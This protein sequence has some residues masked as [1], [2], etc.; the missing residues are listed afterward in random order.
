LLAACE[1]VARAEFDRVDESSVHSPDRAC[2][3]RREL[4]REHG[5]IRSRL[6]GFC[7]NS[8]R[9]RRAMPS[10][11]YS[12]FM[13]D[14]ALNRSRSSAGP[15]PVT[16][17]S[18]VELV[19][20]EVRRSILEG[21]LPPGS[22]VS[23]AELSSRLEV[24]HIPVREALRRLEGEGLIELRRARSAVV[25]SLTTDDL[26]DVFR[27]RGLIEAD[28]FARAV[29]LYTDEDLEEIEAAYDALLREPDDTAE[30]LSARHTRFHRLLYGPAAS[31]W[32]WRVFD[33]LWQAGERYMYLILGT[34]MLDGTPEHF[35]DVHTRLLEAAQ[36]RSVKLAHK[37]VAEHLHSGIDLLAAT[38]KTS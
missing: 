6:A 29:K 10:T 16:Q 35:R 8:T 30:D 21:S 12:I 38:L 37:A 11:I 32:D 19:I 3:A 24:S 36:A 33:I 14:L 18:V 7:A 15:R 5:G 25:A 31:D 4:L 23:I 20:D 34:T 28:M 17:K 2:D 13:A 26:D 1:G 22:P 9:C 27:L